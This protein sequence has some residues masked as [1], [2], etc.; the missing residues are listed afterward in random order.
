MVFDYIKNVGL[1]FEQGE[2]DHI[3]RQVD[4]IGLE[5]VLKRKTAEKME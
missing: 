5:I 1:K 3:M 4:P 2:I